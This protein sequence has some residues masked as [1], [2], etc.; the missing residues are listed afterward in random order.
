MFNVRSARPN[1]SRVYVIPTRLYIFY[2]LIHAQWTAML[3]CSSK[4]S[5]YNGLRLGLWEW[6]RDCSAPRLCCVF[7]PA[8]R[9]YRTYSSQL[10]STTSRVRTDV[11]IGGWYDIHHKQSC[12]H[13]CHIASAIAVC[14][15]SLASHPSATSV[16]PSGAD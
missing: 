4:P 7:G 6:D 3:G 12:V 13:T 5:I 10:N 1:A 2:I 14:D 16:G 8:V 15:V 11:G 9:L